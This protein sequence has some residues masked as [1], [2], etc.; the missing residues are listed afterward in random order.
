MSAGDNAET[1]QWFQDVMLLATG[2]CVVFS[3]SAIV[4]TSNDSSVRLLGRGYLKLR[5]RPRLTL[6]G[7]ASLL[8]VGRTLPSIDCDDPIADTP[9]TPASDHLP[10]QQEL[11]YTAC[12]GPPP[13]HALPV[14][15]PTERANVHAIPSVVPRSED[16]GTS[17]VSANEPASRNGPRAAPAHLKYLIGWLQRNGGVNTPLKL[18]DAMSKLFWVGKKIY[19]GQKHWWITMLEEAKAEGLVEVTNLNVKTKELKA[20]RTIRLLHPGPFTWV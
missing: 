15:D 17:F 5:V 4:M 16:S 19:G 8:A 18:S 14:S 20:Q 13:T 1:A 7:G 9:L 2:Q 6:D 3:P 12:Q 11:S 10:A